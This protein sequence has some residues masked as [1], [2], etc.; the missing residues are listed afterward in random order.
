MKRATLSC[1]RREIAVGDE[2]ALRHRWRG[3]ADGEGAGDFLG[4]RLALRVRFRPMQRAVL[5]A[6]NMTLWLGKSSTP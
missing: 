2:S 3:R 4:R 6:P 1:L 5:D